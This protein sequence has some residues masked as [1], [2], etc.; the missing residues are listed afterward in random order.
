MNRAHLV[1][2]LSEMGT[3]L[4]L[5]G[6]NPFKVKAHQNAARIIETFDGDL[7]DAIKTEAIGEVKGIGPA[8]KEKII[9]FYKT[10][11]I[12]EHEELKK[13]I[14]PGVI[15]M[16]NISG[17][18]PK[19]VRVLYQKLKIQSPQEL[20][21]ACQE[22]KLLEL[23]GFGEKI[24]SKILESLE[25]LKT[26]DHQF[27]FSDAW[28]E[29][30]TIVA[31]L[32]GIKAVSKVE[33]AGS[34]RRKKEVIKDIDILVATKSPEAVGKKFLELPQ[35]KKVTAEGDTKISVILKAGMACDLRMVSLEEF[36]FAL[37]YF[38]GS[39]EHNVV[40]RQKAK[41]RKY[42]L[43]EYGL[44]IEGKT[45][46]KISCATEKDIFNELDLEYIP[47]ELRE[48]NGEF[49]AAENKKTSTVSGARSNPRSVSLPHH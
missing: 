16:L 46:K 19:R 9:Q 42:K 5:L 30:Q 40:M 17:L 8:L 23:D 49:A 27:L 14:P 10:G 26:Q 36:P 24:Q 34:L 43:N 32:S 39:K 31:A 2:L 22:D 44:F 37:L 12:S 47:P 1:E 21:K 6:E 18:G 20:E 28:L 25:F 3:F 41:D 4:D 11:K 35:V 48:N 7:E 13:Q 45:E 15:E 38:T 33:I 29:A